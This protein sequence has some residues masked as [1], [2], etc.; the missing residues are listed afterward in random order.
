MNVGFLDIVNLYI[1]IG[2]VMLIMFCL[3]YGFIFVMIWMMDDIRD[4]LWKVVMK[5]LFINVLLFFIFLGMMFF[6]MDLFSNYSCLMLYIF[7]IGIFVYLLVGFFF[8][9]KKDG[10][11]F[12]MSGLILILLIFFIFVGLFLIVLVS[13]IN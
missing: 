2:G 10:W 4:C 1:I 9:C 12:V 13:L 5:F 8:I 11:V 7:F 6:E 3:W